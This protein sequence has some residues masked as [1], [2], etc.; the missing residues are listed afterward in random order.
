MGDVNQLALNLVNARFAEA[1]AKAQ[2]IEC[3]DAILAQFD[4]AESGSKTVKTDNGIKLTLKTGL[5]YKL[6][7]GADIPA[8]CLKVTTKT[9]LDVKAY[10][11]LRESD[12]MEFG[13][14]SKMVTTTPRKAAVTVAVI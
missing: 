12:P 8:H 1:E 11:A 4:L 3:E 6:D 5:S 7:K 14:V 13:R 10:E 2:R 9:D